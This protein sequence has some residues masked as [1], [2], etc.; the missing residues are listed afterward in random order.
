MLL[1]PEAEIEGARVGDVL[2]RILHAVPV[3]R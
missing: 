1:R 2:D 3:P